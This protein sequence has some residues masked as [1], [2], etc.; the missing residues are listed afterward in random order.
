MNNNWTSK[1]TKIKNWER[2]IDY[3]MFVDENGNSDVKD[4]L[5]CLSKNEQI[6]INNN[7]FT[8]TGVIFTRAQY[9]V[10]KN[11]LNEIKLKYWKK[12]TYLYKENYKKVCFHSRE[13]RR[14][15][16]AFDNN[17]IDYLSF[18]NDISKLIE[19]LDYK[20]ISV[21]IDK[22]NYLLK[23]YQFNVYNTAMCFLLQR[24][25]YV[26]PSNCTGLVMLE[27]RGKDEDYLLL[28]EMKHI[29]FETGIKNI[30]SD[31]LQQKI[32]GIYFNPK[33][34]KCYDD[35]FA[36]LEIADLTSYP[37]HKYVRNK[38]KDRAF[39]ILEKK[40]DKYPNYE[41]K[42]IKIFP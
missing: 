17:L 30:S 12:G 20:I 18:M 31:E 19:D 3:V 1:P 37:I 39:T 7:F 6:D 35:T 15:T 11:K 2:A 16:G 13:I 23:H 5:K 28:N 26:M 40:I 29:I 33:W 34:S 32:A 22:E 9:I 10:A 27:A 41:N 25:I 8:V 14:R 24:Y 4:I 42:G 38:V 21:T 36:G